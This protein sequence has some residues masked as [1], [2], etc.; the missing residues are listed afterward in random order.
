MISQQKNLSTTVLSLGIPAI[1]L[2]FML[3]SVIIYSFYPP[4]EAEDCVVST[5]QLIYYPSQWSI[6]PITIGS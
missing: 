1:V 5:T 6:I 3:A 2:P 4:K